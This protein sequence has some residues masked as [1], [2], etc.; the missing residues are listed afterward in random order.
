MKFLKEQAENKFQAIPIT[1]SL[2]DGKEPEYYLEGVFVQTNIKNR[3]GRIY[4]M[5]IV[6]PEIE[7]YKREYIDRNRA[8]GQLNHPSNGSPNIDLKEVSHLITDIWQDGDYFK[9]R[10]KILDTPNGRIVKALIKE[11][12]QLGVST[13]AMGSVTHK[14]DADYV[15]KDFR[16]ITAGDVVFEPSSQIAFPQGLMEDVE[17]TYDEATDSYNPVLVDK[18]EVL[19]EK[20][21]ESIE[22]KTARQVSDFKCLLDSFK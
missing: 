2:E 22:A 19:E 14:K 9:C 13:R 11:G 16:L 17:Y 4:P 6:R 7:R 1:E 8:L 12:C 3:N 15:N 21:E 5:D 18:A 10:A 20:A